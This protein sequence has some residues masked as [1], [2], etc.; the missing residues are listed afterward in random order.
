MTPVNSKVEKYFEKN[1]NIFDT[2][3]LSYDS[4]YLR[5]KVKGMLQ[6]MYDL[7]RAD[8]Y[9]DYY[10]DHIAEENPNYE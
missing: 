4:T 1:Q 6:E 10:Y 2:L 7:G 9:A 3:D 5:N 8:G